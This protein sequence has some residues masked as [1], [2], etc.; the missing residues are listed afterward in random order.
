VELDD[1]LRTQPDARGGG[2]VVQDD[3]LVY[4][5]VYAAV[6]LEDDG[7]VLHRR[8]CDQQACCPELQGAEA[9]LDGQVG[10]ACAGAGEDGH[11]APCGLDR[12]ADDLVLF[13]L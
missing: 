11:A 6:V 13:G 7:V 9:L 4:R 10:A 3:E 8:R 5:G 1:Q 2:I 12:H